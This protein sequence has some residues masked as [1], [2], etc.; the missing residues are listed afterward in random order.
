MQTDKSSIVSNI[1]LYIVFSLSV[2]FAS[3]TIPL[4]CGRYGSVNL[5]S[6]SYF[7]HIGANI[8]SFLA[9]VP[10]LILYILFE[11]YNPLSVNIFLL[12][13]VKKFIHSSMTSFILNSIKLK[14][15]SNLLVLNISFTKINI[16]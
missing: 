2:L 14:S 7:L 8:C 16:R 5:C 12:L 15:K 10:F 1:Y 11:N 4:V 13:K 9:G 3:Y 6:I